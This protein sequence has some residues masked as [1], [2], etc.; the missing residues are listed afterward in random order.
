MCKRPLLY[1]KKRTVLENAIF[2][3]S[4]VLFKTK[5]FQ[6]SFNIVLE[7]TGVMI[8]RRYALIP[9]KKKTRNPDS[10]CQMFCKS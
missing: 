9:K 8:C 3:K 10:K 1:S 6:A 4:P 5:M 7:G 2:G